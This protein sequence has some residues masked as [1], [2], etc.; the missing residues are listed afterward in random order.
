MHLKWFKGQQV[1]EVMRRVRA[2]LGPEAVI[3]H[4]K[5][6]RPWGPLRFV[7]SGGV[8]ILAAVDR[9][10]P[11]RIP[12]AP[13]AQPDATRVIHALRGE[14]ADLRTLF[15]RFAGSRLLPPALGPIYERL[16]SA[17]M[18]SALAIR[19]LS[20]FPPLQVD[21]SD[22]NASKGPRAVAEYLATRIAVANCGAGRGPARIALV[23]P[24]G[25]GK[26]TTLAK[27]AARA[28]IAGGRIAI[29]N[30]DG[31]GFSGSGALEAF[32]GILDVPHLTALTPA[33]LGAELQLPAMRGCV[34][35]DTPGIR[36]ADAVGLGKLAEL[37]RAARPDEVHLVLSAATKTAD[38]LA[39][40]RAFSGAGVT[41]LLFTHLDETASC[42]SVIGASV[43]SG[44]P[45]S[46]VGTGRDIPGDLRPAD[47]LDIVH[48]TLEGAH[49]S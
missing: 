36:S 7:K 25:G 2:E 47:A 31:S 15:V 1:P 40:V 12:A 21:T 14:V 41:H 34:L 48:R 17:G 27:L 10:E 33:E 28:Q 3:L 24:A 26:T 8:E 16:I 29:V 19:L 9:A 32:A 5:T 4:S 22:G 38:A 45:L 20:N 39:A 46:Y 11:P 43:E 44:L 35:I 23:G 18:E 13:A 6:A 49:T 37:L 42:A 30:A